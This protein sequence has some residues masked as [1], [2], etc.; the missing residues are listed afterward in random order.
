M[1]SETRFSTP[2]TSNGQTTS[3]QSYAFTSRV[4]VTCKRSRHVIRLLRFPKLPASHAC[5]REPAVTSPNSNPDPR[6]LCLFRQKSE[7]RKSAVSSVS[8]RQVSKGGVNRGGP[9]LATIGDTK[10]S[11][12]ALPS[13]VDSSAGD[14]R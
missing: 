8:A 2:P 11:G 12:L 3:A 1:A 4:G 13:L 10:H 6:S 9:G 14:S 7:G 5:Y